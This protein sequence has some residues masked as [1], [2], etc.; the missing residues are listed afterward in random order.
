MQ[1]CEIECRFSFGFARSNHPRATQS[2]I[3]LAK[4]KHISRS[5]RVK[6][7]WERLVFE[8]NVCWFFHRAHFLFAHHFRKM[9][10]HS[11]EFMSF[12]CA[13][14]M[15][16]S[17]FS[18]RSQISASTDSVKIAHTVNVT[19]PKSPMSFTF[20]H[21]NTRIKIVDIFVEIFENS[22]TFRFAHNV[23]ARRWPCEISISFV[24]HRT[25]NRS[26]L[27]TI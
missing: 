13:S 18:M 24:A 5:A 12:V 26:V 6:S 1:V 16:E 21:G 27:S 15:C 17:T 4:S 9:K 25:P 14:T 8:I 2:R 3:D 22:A 20:W 19:Q 23:C 10:Q 11:D 7:G